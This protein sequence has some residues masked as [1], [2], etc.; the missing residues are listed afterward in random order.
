MRELVSFL[1]RIELEDFVEMGYPEAIKDFNIEE[2]I[3]VCLNS[4]IFDIQNGLVIKV[5]EGLEVVQAYKGMRKLS[6]EEI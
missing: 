3:G 6:K 1:I 2:D 5:A 4:S